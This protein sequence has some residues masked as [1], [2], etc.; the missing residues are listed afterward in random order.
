VLIVVRH[1]QTASNAAR[2]L[3]G[4]MDPPLTELGL[5]Q[6]EG[7]SQAEGVASSARVVTSPLRRC[8]DTA[9]LLGPPVDVDERWVEM[10]YGP[11]DGMPL[12]EVP[13][14][15]WAAWRHDPSWAPPGGESLR[16]VG[17]RVRAACGELAAE[18]ARHD[19][20][21]VSHV[22]PIKAAVAWALGVGDDV[23]WRMFVDVASLCR[24]STGPAAPS[25]RSFNEIHHRPSH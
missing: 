5:R 12:D 14:E 10:D 22:S 13:A 25:L 11:Y 23:V 16:A 24:M 8:R 17:E 6:A 20:V 4:R 7:L 9:A 21:V 18:A 1:G 19:I 15:I 3:L 2:L